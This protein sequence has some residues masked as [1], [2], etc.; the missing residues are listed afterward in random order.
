VSLTNAIHNTLSKFSPSFDL[1]FGA[2]IPGSPGLHSEFSRSL[3][4][5]LLGGIGYFYGESKVD[6]SHAAEYEEA[7]LLFW[8][9]TA[10]GSGRTQPTMKGPSE[11]FTSVPSRP[12]FP[13]GFLWD[14]GFH[15]LVVL[16]WDMDLALEVVKSWFALMDAD[17]WIA[18]EQI[19]GFEARSKVPLEFQTQYPHHANPPTLY[20]VIA[21]FIDR[22]S[23]AVVYSG[24]PS[25]YLT[26]AAAAEELLFDLYPK[27]KRHYEWFRRTQAG[28]MRSYDRPGKSSVEG[29]RWRGRTP[30]HTL[31]SGLDDY[32]RTQPPHPGELHVDALSWVGVMARALRSAAAFLG[33]VKDLDRFEV[34]DEAIEQSLEDLHWSEEDQTYCDATIENDKHI[35]V[36]HKGYVSL[37]PFFLGLLGTFNPHMDAILDLIRSEDG[38]WSPYGL[39]S[40]SR[41]NSL[42]GTDEN[43]WRGPIWI[44]INYLAIQQLL[45]RVLLR[46]FRYTSKRLSN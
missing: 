10:E 5:N 40:L 24:S 22:L 9:K 36:C 27:L 43:Y 15:L 16:D 1:A 35:M 23:G 4:S 39:R 41:E 34:Q 44:N 26:H 28:D 20:L 7:N 25:Y 14:E 12:F 32:P 38:L 8:D 30:Q 13:R 18:R 2:T 45:V 3:L 42:Y 37:F 46:H 6:T 19:L 21:A 17:G 33:E 31:T 29:Y 11:L